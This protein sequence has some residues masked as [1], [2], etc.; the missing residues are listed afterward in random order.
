[1]GGAG[2]RP[3]RRPATGVGSPHRLTTTGLGCAGRSPGTGLGAPRRLG[4][5]ASSTTA[6]AG[7]RARQRRAAGAAARHRPDLGGILGI[8]FGAISLS[9]IRRTNQ[10]GRGMAI[11]GI[12]LGTLWF[13]IFFGIGL[14]TALSES[15]GG[16]DGGASGVRRATAED[17]RLGTVRAEALRVG[18]CPS[19]I[20]DGTV[21][22]VELGSCSQPHMGE[23]YAV[24]DLP[25]SGYPGE[26]EVARFANGGCSDRLTTFVGAARQG[27]FD[28]FYLVPVKSS[29][30]RGERDVQCILTH[31][32]GSP[33][34]PGSAK[35]G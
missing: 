13:L 11:A 20:P 29:W 19:S 28:A 15:G 21:R 18:D 9:R 32:D 3:G 10:S 34:P 7:H 22:T 35:A 33:L 23:V 17:M 2:R 30:D 27:A 5:A 16:G 24:F 1:M 4:P 26:A 8:A 6:A 14:A 12:V 25:G 31:E